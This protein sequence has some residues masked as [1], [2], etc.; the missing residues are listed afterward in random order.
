MD[1]SNFEQ[2]VAECEA[3]DDYW[4]EMRLRAKR[5]LMP[6][7]PATWLDKIEAQLPGA[8]RRAPVEVAKEFGSLIT[9]QIEACRKAMDRGN[10]QRTKILFVVLEE[11][12][13]RLLFNLALSTSVPIRE[14]A[15]KGGNERNQRYQ[16]QRGEYQTFIDELHKRRPD[17][18]CA[19]LQRQA[20][21]HFECSP[22][23][24]KRYT[25]N[26]HKK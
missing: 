24:I 23:T 17:F 16:K 8:L 22:R 1:D 5:T 25:E 6:K 14:G 9:D 20:A 26:P 21:R 3:A 11:N 18:T 10:E 12:C 4:E 13:S 7:D 15:R 2:F 19:E